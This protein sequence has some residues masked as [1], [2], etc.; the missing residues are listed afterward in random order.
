MSEETLTYEGFTVSA[1]IEPAED[2]DLWSAVMTISRDTSDDTESWIISAGDTYDSREEALAFFQQALDRIGR[3][4]GVELVGAASKLPLR[5]EGENHNGLM[6]ED[7]PVE[8]GSMPHVALSILVLP[9]Y[10][11]TMGIR[12]LEGRL[13]DQVRS[14]Y[15]D[16]P[17]EDGGAWFFRLDPRS[18]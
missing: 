17:I 18:A 12:L 6:I 7:R 8:Q 13:I 1:K 15:G 2:T 5:P 10:F 4:P 16:L 14:K 11:E 9:G 3:V